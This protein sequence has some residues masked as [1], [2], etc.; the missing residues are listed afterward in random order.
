VVDAIDNPIEVRPFRATGK[1][2]DQ[3][4]ESESQQA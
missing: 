3:M 1:V 4:A 2:A